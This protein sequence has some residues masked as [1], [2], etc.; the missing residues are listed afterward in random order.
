[1][2]RRHSLFQQ[3]QREKPKSIKWR[4]FQFIGP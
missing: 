1:L 2:R 3:S 4:H